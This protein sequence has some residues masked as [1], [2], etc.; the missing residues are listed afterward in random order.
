MFRPEKLQSE[1]PHN[2]NAEPSS[3]VLLHKITRKITNSPPPD[4]ARAGVAYPWPEQIEEKKPASRT[5]ID[6]LCLFLVG[7]SLYL[8]IYQA[9]EYRGEQVS[10]ILP[11]CTKILERRQGT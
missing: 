1:I 9:E 11:F 4:W 6:V 2:A 10:S 8:V 5:T 7:M 3:G